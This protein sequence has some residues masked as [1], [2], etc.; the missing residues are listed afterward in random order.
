MTL[1][2]ILLIACTERLVYR[3]P[4]SGMLFKYR[5]YLDCLRPSSRNG[6]ARLA[7]GVSVPDEHDL[8]NKF[9]LNLHIKLLPL[10]PTVNIIEGVAY[11]TE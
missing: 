11:L 9:I 5:I 2:V 10:F 4:V 8:H 1:N 6:R 3:L 7:S